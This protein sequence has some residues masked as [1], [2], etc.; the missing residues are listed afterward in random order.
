MNPYG[1]TEI[2]LE[3]LHKYVSKELL[4]KVN[5]TT[6]IP[7]KTP[8]VINKT[9]ILWVHNSYD[10]PNLYP[11]FKNKLNH[12]KYDW[13]VF[14]SHWTYEKYRMIFDI[15]TDISLVIKNGFDDD[16]IVKSE[17]KPKEKLKLVYTSTPWRGLDVLLSAMEQIKTDKVELD[18]YSST[19]IYGDYFK[20]ISDNQ[21]T[22]LYDKAKTIK[23]VNYKGYLN[24]KELMKILHTYDAYIHPSTFEET[25]CLAAM[26]SLAAGLV[27]VTT[28]L[29]ALYETCAEF[30]I[31]VP[32]LKDK[33]ALSKQFAGAIDILPDFINSLNADAMK[34][35]M[36]YYR[37]FY[38]WNVIK[39]YWERFLNGI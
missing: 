27:T 9:N 30:P 29:G 35:Q 38:H 7:E 32:Y 14:N 1:G 8:L 25:F 34:F 12:R 10:Q 6:S 22:A 21:F 39:T 13:Y 31:Y 28:D 16:L 15:P 11:W 33:E 18:I 26:E 5:I 2:Q 19:Q 17:F 37:Q 24:H 23:N 3:Y 4:D 20:Q 36:Q